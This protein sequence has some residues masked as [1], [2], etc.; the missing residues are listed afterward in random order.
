MASCPR[1]IVQTALTLMG[2]KGD[3]DGQS[4]P[5]P[6]VGYEAF[7]L[8]SLADQSCP[9][10]FEGYEESFHTAVTGGIVSFFVSPSFC[11]V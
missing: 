8:L 3:S 11:G 1:L 7:I 6:F 2:C 5:L 10:P 4:C 9:P